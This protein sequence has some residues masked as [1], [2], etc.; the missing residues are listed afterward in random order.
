[1]SRASGKPNGVYHEKERHDGEG[2]GKMEERKNFEIYQ[3]IVNPSLNGGHL[4][5]GQFSRYRL[6][7]SRLESSQF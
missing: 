5:P 2:E 7:G 4:F 3:E 1:M 6:K